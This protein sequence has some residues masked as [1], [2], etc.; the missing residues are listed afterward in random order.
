[1]TYG[2]PCGLAMSVINVSTANCSAI[3]PPGTYA[4][5]A[6][7]NSIAA[8][9]TAR[10]WMFTTGFTAAGADGPGGADGGAPVLH[11]IGTSLATGTIAYDVVVTNPFCDVDTYIGA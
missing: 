2:S 7:L 3:S 6:Q 5:F 4:A 10:G 11:L 1:M 8:V 9:D